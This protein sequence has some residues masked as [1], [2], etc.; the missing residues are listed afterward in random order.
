M[1][2]I[3]TTLKRFASEDSGLET[4]EWAV[5]GGLIVGGI[6][7]VVTTLGGNVLTQFTK[8]SNA[9]PAN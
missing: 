1:R 7:V 8:L 4:V 6:V 9:I 3:L 5:I 2:S